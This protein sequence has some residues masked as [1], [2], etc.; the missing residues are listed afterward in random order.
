MTDARLS[1]WELAA[2]ALALAADVFTVSL[3]VGTSGHARTVRPALRLAF[4]FGL[5]QGLMT[6]LGWGAGY[7]LARLISTIDHWV[8][9]GLLTIVGVRMIRASLR[10]EARPFTSDP[11]RGAMMVL[12]SVATSLD[13]FGVGL[14]LEILQTGVAA[15]AALIGGVSFAMGLAGLGLGGRLSERFGQR[16]GAVGGI[17]LIAIGV[18]VVVTHLG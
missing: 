1:L 13:A 14:S 3:G 4:H 16:L 15:S 12:L 18:R 6:V 5:F 17:V 8:A 7:G 9:L 11:T 2:L 10:P